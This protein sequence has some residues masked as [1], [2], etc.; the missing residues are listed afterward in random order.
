MTIVISY[1]CKLLWGG[2]I[3]LLSVL[4][5][6]GL[7]T[8]RSI[9]WYYLA[10]QGF[11][12]PHNWSLK[13]KNPTKKKL[14]F[15]SRLSLTERYLQTSCVYFYVVKYNHMGL[16]T[17]WT[18][19]FASRNTPLL[20]NANRY[21]PSGLGGCA[22]ASHPLLSSYA[23]L[24]LMVLSLRG[25]TSST[26]PIQW[27]PT[28]APRSSRLLLLRYLRS[29]RYEFWRSLKDFRIE[30]FCYICV[31]FRKSLSPLSLVFRLS[32]LP[33]SYSLSPVHPLI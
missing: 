9:N 24:P 4:K 27:H 3:Q 23:Y 7:W 21:A 15:I 1:D 25:S 26:N 31:V 16:I 12:L 10:C 28:S 6:V 17:W 18:P 11:S 14:R 19:Q 22:T 5:I 2:F 20:I 8:G 29:L 30:L 13:I 33:L 32:P